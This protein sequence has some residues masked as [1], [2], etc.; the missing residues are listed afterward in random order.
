M[1]NK[2]HVSYYPVRHHNQFRLLINALEFYPAILNSINQA[3]SE[4]VIENYLTNSGDVFS[5]FITALLQA[6]KRGVTIYCLFDSFGSKGISQEDLSLL[7]T[8]NIHVQFYNRIR[9]HKHLRNLFRDHRKIF[10]IDR[11]LVYIGGA[12]LSDQFDPNSKH[13][14]HDIMLSVQGEIVQDWFLLFKQNWNKENKSLLTSQV[15]NNNT[16]PSFTKFKQTGKIITFTAPHRQEI[17]KHL[18]REINKSKNIILLTTP[19]FVPSRK[20]RRA[21]IRASERG[22]DVKLMLPGKITDHPAVRIIGQRHYAQLL[23]HGITIF[24]FSTHFSHAKVL[25]CDDWVTTGSSNF[26]RWN[27]KWNLEANQTISDLNFA[28]TI[29]HWF[30]EELSD[31]KEINYEQWRNRSRSQRIKEWFW[32]IVVQMLEKLKRPP[33]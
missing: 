13:A 9:Y 22:V 15:N 3:Q 27:F 11:S 8:N 18:L 4:I 33:N 29:K 21:L 24:E 31:C 10:I 6:A 1:A 25:L 19:Y 12:G 32:G 20:L 30:E 7:N 26:D 28:V 16:P 14:W 2:N 5:Q 17:K 23:R